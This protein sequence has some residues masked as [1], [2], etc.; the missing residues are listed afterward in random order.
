MEESECALIVASGSASQLLMP[1]ALCVV[2]DA[3]S[4]FSM[5]YAR[6]GER[7]LLFLARRTLDVEVAGDLTAETFAIAFCSWPRLQE[8]SE[9]EVRAWLFTVARRQLSRYFRRAR[10]ERGAVERLGI[11][12]P[13]LHEDDVALIEERAGLAELRVALGVELARLSGEQREALR[14]RVVEDLPYGEVAR[15]LGVSEQAA[16]ARVSRGLRSLAGALEPY[17]AGGELSG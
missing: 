7:V 14:L 10:V 16:R 6:E 8:R 15:L 11:R 17:R 1:A 2:V 12:V 9:A 5:V 13:Q 4:E 3:G